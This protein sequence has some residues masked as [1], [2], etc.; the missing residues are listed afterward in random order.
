[1]ISAASFSRGVPISTHRS[2]KRPYSGNSS[3]FFLTDSGAVFTSVLTAMRKKR[4]SPRPP[5]ASRAKKI[6]FIVLSGS[7]AYA[8]ATVF[9]IS[10]GEEFLIAPVLK[11]ISRQK[12]SDERKAAAPFSV[13]VLL[14]S[15]FRKFSI[16][17][18]LPAGSPRELPR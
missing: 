17:I 1:M 8:R 5:L 6:I 15:F 13:Y 18:L 16:V 10:S 9:A 12:D 11:N 3:R 14:A 4:L 7:S 2:S